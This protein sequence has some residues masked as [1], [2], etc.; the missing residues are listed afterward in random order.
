[1]TATAETLAAPLPAPEPQ[2]QVRWEPWALGVLLVG[3]GVAYI[4]G[5]G[6]SG[7]ANSFYA[8]AVQ[9]GSVSWKASSAPRTLQTRSPST[10]R[11]CPCG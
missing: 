11:P 6:A 7:W 5:L 2:R 10:S 4:W 9:A 8:A 1:M 3:T